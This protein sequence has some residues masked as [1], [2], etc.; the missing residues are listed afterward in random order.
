MA[1]QRGR[2]LPDP[3]FDPSAQRATTFLLPPFPVLARREV[4]LFLTSAALLYT[5]LLLI[6]WVPA[7]VIYVGFFSNFILMGSFLGIGVG[8]LYGRA[9]A[10]AGGRTD[11]GARRLPVP[12][13]A[14]L[15][16]AVVALIG[17]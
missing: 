13:F 16:L 15:L 5:E 7:E 11:A 6:R 17:T 1:P 3:R 8:I 14:V 2:P 10:S 12:P 9:T 4:R